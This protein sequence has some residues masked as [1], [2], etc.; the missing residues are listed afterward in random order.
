MLDVFIVFF[1]A[2][3]IQMDILAH[4]STSCLLD[5]FFEFEIW[6]KC[7]SIV[8]L[9]GVWRYI[10]FFRQ[11]SNLTVSEKNILIKLFCL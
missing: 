4:P 7:F 2:P 6:R 8:N 1:S 5:V 10:Q 3:L 11:I 9:Y